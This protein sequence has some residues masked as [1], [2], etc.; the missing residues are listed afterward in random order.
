MLQARSH[1]AGS[2]PC[3]PRNGQVESLGEITYYARRLQQA[4]M[5]ET[6]FAGFTLESVAQGRQPY[7]PDQNSADEILQGTAQRF[8]SAEAR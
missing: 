6:L 5:Q 8:R 4:E 3:N 7:L 1:V 2:I